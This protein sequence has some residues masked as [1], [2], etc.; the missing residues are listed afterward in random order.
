DLGTLV[1]IAAEKAVCAVAHTV[2]E[3][4]VYPV[5]RAVETGL[6]ADGVSWTDGDGPSEGG[7]AVVV[8]DCDVNVVRTIV[9]IPEY[10]TL[11]ANSTCTWVSC[12]VGCAMF[13]AMSLSCG[14][15]RTV[16]VQS[17]IS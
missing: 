8:G 15:V 1:R 16:E 17:V 14:H 13:S 7:L 2:I 11:T 4:D 10:Q 12:V 3:S 9:V 6:D 5:D